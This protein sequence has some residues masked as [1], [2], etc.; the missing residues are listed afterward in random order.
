[1]ATQYSLGQQFSDW[2]ACFTRSFK[3]NA[4]GYLLVVF[5]PMFVLTFIYGLVIWFFGF[6][7]DLPPVDSLDAFISFMLSDPFWVTMIVVAVLLFLLT[8]FLSV[9]YVVMAV[10]TADRALQGSKQEVA[11]F[12]RTVSEGKLRIVGLY[13]LYLLMLSVFAL[14]FI[15]LLFGL[16]WRTGLLT[17]FLFIVI[18]LVV[19]FFSVRLMYSWFFIILKG[20]GVFASIRES[21]H[22]VRGQWWRTFGYS[23]LLGLMVAAASFAVGIV[24]FILLLPLIFLGD[25]GVIIMDIADD[26]LSFLLNAVWAPLYIS[27]FVAMFSGFLKEA[28]QN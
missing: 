17:A 19:T 8:I 6:R 18:F 26:A 27:Y 25:S 7:S 10:R 16:S 11:D 5:V 22:L 21:W 24:I 1:M 9:W 14:A 3:A 4:V 13:I 23:A 15:P 12:F 20:R 2:W 28:E